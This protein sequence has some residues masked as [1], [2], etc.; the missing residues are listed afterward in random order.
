MNEHEQQDD[1]GLYHPDGFLVGKGPQGDDRQLPGIGY[2]RNRPTLSPEPSR[3]VPTIGRPRLLITGMGTL[4]PLATLTV[5]SIRRQL[6]RAVRA[7]RG[8]PAR[9]QG[10]VARTLPQPQQRSRTLWPPLLLS[11]LLGGGA[12]LFYLSRRDDATRAQMRRAT[13]TL[14]QGAANLTQRA[15]EGAK[16]LNLRTT[17]RAVSAEGTALNTG[18]RAQEERT[19]I[20][21]RAK[22]VVG[23]PIADS[24][25]RLNTAKRI[26]DNARDVAA[27][28]APQLG[29]QVEAQPQR[30]T[31]SSGTTAPGATK[32]GVTAEGVAASV[33]SAARASGPQLAARIVARMA[34]LDSKGARVGAVD[35][36]EADGSIKLTKDGQGKHHWLP[37]GWVA[38][39]DT[40][41]H[42]DRTIR[43]ARQEWKTSPSKGR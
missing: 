19:D 36:V 4:L 38:R 20:A 17:D 34:V 3:G 23:E 28:S 11:T 43:Q 14:R 8:D 15:Q 10:S 40:H 2:R 9:Q 32:G 37:R 6:W 12:T 22:A 31:M 42:L 7:E 18:F 21:T 1:Q 24:R 27:S 26:E 13:D 30:P 25:E 41:V 16:N 5:P 33:T 35:R 39:V 29:E